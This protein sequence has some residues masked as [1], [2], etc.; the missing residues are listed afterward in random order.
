MFVDFKVENLDT[1]PKTLEKLLDKQ[2]ERI[3]N[4]ASLDNASYESIS[5]P[6]QD[7]DEELGLFFTPLSHLNSV[8]NSQ[9]TQKAYEASLP[10][11]S[12]F[13]SKVAQNEKLFAQ[14]E[15]L[16]SNDIASAK[17]IE[18]EKRDFILGGIKL[19][20]EDKKLL[21]DINLELSEL[22]N[23]FSQNLLD[24]TNDYELIIEDAN[25]VRELPK[26]DLESAKIIKDDKEVYR[27]TLQMPSY[28]AYM[29]YG[30]NRE[31]REELYR[32]YSSRAPENG[33]IIDKLLLLKNQK[34]HLLGFENYSSYSL[35]TK[36]A[37]SQERVIEFLEEIV[38]LSKPTAIDE[39]NELKNFAKELDGI[40]ELK[41]HDVAYYSQKLK[42]EKF[43]FDDS[44]TKPY[45][46]QSRVVDGLLEILSTLFNVEIKETNIKNRW[47]ECVRVFDF[48]EDGK[49]LSRLY[50]DLEAR[51]SKRGGAWM[52]DFETRFI[53]SNNN[54]HLASA[55]IVCNFSPASDTTPSLLRHDD[56][57]TL[58]HEMGHAI[59]HIFSKASQR[60]ISGVNGVAWDVIEFPSQFLENFAYES[61]IL[62]KFAFHYE[63]F[64]PI[65]DTLLSKIK[66]SK[67]F[68]ASLGLL[69]QMEFSL[70]D[71]KL[72]QKLY[73]NQEVQDLLDSI[74]EE[75]SLIKPPSYNKFQNG[76]AHIFAGG[77]SAGYF[78]YKWAEVLSADAFF[79]SIEDGGFN[80]PKAQGYKEN[81]L[82]KGG[83]K[84][85]SELYFDWLGRE[86][87]TK[88]LLR[89]Y[90]LE[91]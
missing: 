74:R 57:V 9:D 14:I 59:H 38:K 20:D 86:A 21:E 79:E 37:P 33:D 63:T 35:A 60:S 28:L 23:K 82:A 36:D 41:N 5:K 64:E 48:Y 67:N 10:L 12:A 40:E 89:L 8:N 45:F 50:M 73:Q 51:E 88:S 80:L 90:G 32:A 11:L 78:S 70:F 71:F 18:N 7:L 87:E 62:K 58:F 85:M 65:S 29:T 13:S 17:V 2:L 84:N 25:D 3:E 22:A 61:E 81:I 19:N 53:D 24:A 31:F 55:F 1:F 75:T 91:R 34:S 44:M 77:Y 16:S 54:L 15:R 69:R 56:V 43:D 83:T 68:Q 27:F 39:L 72:H 76:F 46:E 52:H 42:K 4:I 6:L 26:S 49:V 47:H 30:S 66:E